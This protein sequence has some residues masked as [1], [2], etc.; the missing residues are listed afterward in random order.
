M[1]LTE[2]VMFI[3]TVASAIFTVFS[4]LKTI[5]EEQS[6]ITVQINL[7]LIAHEN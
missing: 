4:Y 1:T 2:T 6:I 5:T 3:C 7:I